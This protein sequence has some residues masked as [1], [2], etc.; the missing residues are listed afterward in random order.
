MKRGRRIATV[1]A[2]VVA[3][4]LCSACAEPAISQESGGCH[5]EVQRTAGVIQPETSGLSC[6]QI[7]KLIE[8]QPSEPGGFLL[9]GDEP[10]R[11]WKCRIY[12]PQKSKVLLGCTHHQKHFSVVKGDTG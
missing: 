3:C 7:K 9:S 10:H 4:A 8:V 2:V 12:V 6:A 5:E 11:T 1:C